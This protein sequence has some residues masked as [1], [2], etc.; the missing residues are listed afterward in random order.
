M[1]LVSDIIR[2][3][4]R[5]SN[6][7]S[8]TANPTTLEQDEGLRLLN[9]FVASTRGTEAGEELDP[10][11][12]GRGHINRPSGYPWYDQIPDAAEWFVPMNVRLVLNLTSPQTLYLDPNPTDGARFA[13]LDK[14]GNLSTNN[15]TVIGNGRTIG[16]ALQIVVS[17]N[18]ANTEY[19]YRADLGDWLPVAPLVAG[20]TFPFPIEF[21][22]LFSIGLAMRLN[23]RHATTADPQSTAAYGRLLHQFKA[24]YR[25]S[26]QMR[27]EL[28]LIRTEGTKRR[29]YDNTRFGNS[30]FDSGWA[31]PFGGYRW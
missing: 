1:T 16:N 5:E 3:A 23:P 14:S 22:S 2:D 27:S 28:G 12:I 20:D 11:L 15:L 13:I 31:S 18:G 30:M 19:I 29:Y 6:L 10:I 24:R 4:Y 17:T 25:Q 9:G 8:I 26:R 21:D 7:I